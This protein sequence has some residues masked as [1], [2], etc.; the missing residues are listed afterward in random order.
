MAIFKEK[1]MKLL[2]KKHGKATCEI[3]LDP[4]T[5]EISI[6]NLTDKQADLPFYKGITPTY[7]DIKNLMEERCFPHSRDKLKLHLRELDIQEYDTISILRKTKGKLEG[8]FVSLEIEE[9]DHE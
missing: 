1:K 5:K 6:K 3:T 2:Y 7:Q 8:D 4:Q 9:K